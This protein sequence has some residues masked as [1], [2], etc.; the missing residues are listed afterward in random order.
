MDEKLINKQLNEEF[1][2]HQKAVFEGIVPQGLVQRFING[3]MTLPP[4]GH[5]ILCSAIRSIINKTEEELTHEEVGIVI[6][7]LLNIPFDKLYTDL[8]EALDKHTEFE[9]FVVYYNQKVDAL[10]QTLN[11]KKDALMNLGGVR[12]NSMSKIITNG[13]A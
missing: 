13:Q 9:N 8:F 5:K 3:I 6:K 1:E 4:H 10:Q 2:K 11:R 12:K 7:V